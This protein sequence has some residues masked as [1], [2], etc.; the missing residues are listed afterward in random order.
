MIA[1]IVGDPALFAIECAKSNTPS[2]GSFGNVRLRFGDRHLGDFSEE[3]WLDPVW[4]ALDN[5]RSHNIG[6]RTGLLFESPLRVPP[7]AEMLQ[8]G[9][10][11]WA[12]AFDDYRYVYYGIASER[13]IHFVWSGPD[14]AAPPTGLTGQHHAR[15]PFTSFDAV[16]GETL[17]RF[18]ARPAAGR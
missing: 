8:L 14:R 7:F 5:L 18:G 13:T 3:I 11:S 17:E 1:E 15:V 10:W 2:Y 9:G 16:V 4:D 6:T 12:E